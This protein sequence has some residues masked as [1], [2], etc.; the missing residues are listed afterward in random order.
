MEAPGK[1]EVLFILAQNGC[2][3]EI[4]EAVKRGGGPVLPCRFGIFGAGCL[5]MAWV[6]SRRLWGKLRGTRA[7]G[8]RKKRGDQLPWSKWIND[9]VLLGEFG[10]NHWHHDGRHNWPRAAQHQQVSR[11]RQPRNPEELDGSDSTKRDVFVS[12][13]ALV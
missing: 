1:K 9:G 2:L 12:K 8:R 5:L 11:D 4:E 13:G 3:C 7:N 6:A 10:G